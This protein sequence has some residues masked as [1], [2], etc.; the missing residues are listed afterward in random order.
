MVTAGTVFIV[1]CSSSG[2]CSLPFG[3]L[4]CSAYYPISSSDDEQEFYFLKPNSSSDNAS[5][6]FSMA[7]TSPCADLD[8]A[9]GSGSSE[10]GSGAIEMPLLL[11]GCNQHMLAYSKAWIGITWIFVAATILYA[12]ADCTSIHTVV[13]QSQSAAVHA[14]V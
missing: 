6:H 3:D 4:D 13:A 10:D 14:R 12:D 11:V 2:D 8:W 7:A 5:N 1:K 9:I